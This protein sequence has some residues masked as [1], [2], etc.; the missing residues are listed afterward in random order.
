[1][2]F[3]EL[4]RKDGTRFLIDFHSHWEI[5]DRGGNPALWQNHEQARNMN[6][7]NTYDEVR[8]KLLKKEPPMTTTPTS[9]AADRAI[10]GCPE[11]NMGNYNEVEVE[12]LNDWAI[13]AH[14]EIDRLHALAAGQATA[15]PAQPAAQQ[16]GAA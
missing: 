2:N 14:D 5:D 4:K 7:A 8:A 15:A 6:C 12:R 10:E 16:G 11:L 9:G 13:R 1:M 3:V